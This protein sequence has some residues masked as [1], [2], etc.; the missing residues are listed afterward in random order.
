ML[1]NRP[2]SFIKSQNFETGLSDDDDDDD[3]DNDDDDGGDK[4]FCGVVDQR[5]AFSLISSRDN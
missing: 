3:D 4:L 2:R 1:T 5:K